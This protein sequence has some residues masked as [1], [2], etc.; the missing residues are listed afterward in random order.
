MISREPTKETP[1]QVQHGYVRR[2]SKRPNCDIELSDVVEGPD[3]WFIDG[4]ASTEKEARGFA[5]LCQAKEAKADRYGMWF[6]ITECEDWDE[7]SGYWLNF[8]T[9]DV[10]DFWMEGL[11]M[12]R[13]ERR[14][15]VVDIMMRA[16]DLEGPAGATIVLLRAL[17]ER[18]EDPN[19]EAMASRDEVEGYV[20]D[21]RNW[22]GGACEPELAMRLLDMARAKA[23][24]ALS[25]D[26]F[27][28]E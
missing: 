15:A 28:E 3:E 17:R 22:D 27:E 5:A 25:K 20:S 10:I 18:M 12:S 8:E 2:R 23:M 26:Y 16:I 6:D 19:V 4:Y 13:K 9:V 11:K 21:K 14:E 1:F 7:D 24:G